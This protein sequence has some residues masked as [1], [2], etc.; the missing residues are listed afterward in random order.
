MFWSIM[1]QMLT[2]LCALCNGN[3][4][5]THKESAKNSELKQQV[6][7][8]TQFVPKKIYKK[9]PRIQGV[10]NFYSHPPNKNIA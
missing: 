3:I 7:F 5:K 10:L 8:R 2:K 4:L 1:L 6:K 9:P